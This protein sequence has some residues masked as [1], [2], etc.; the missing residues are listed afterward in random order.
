[1]QNAAPQHE[2]MPDG[3]GIGALFCDIKEDPPCVAEAAAHKQPKADGRKSWG[4]N[5]ML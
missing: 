2:Q 5:R 3:M 1:M 4:M